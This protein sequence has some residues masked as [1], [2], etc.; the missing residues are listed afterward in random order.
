MHSWLSLK[1][2]INSAWSKVWLKDGGAG[3]A[4]GAEVLAAGGVLAGSDTALC[5]PEEPS[6][7]AVPDSTAPV[8]VHPAASAAVSSRAA[9][10]QAAVRGRWAMRLTRS[11]RLRLPP[12]RVEAVTSSEGARAQLMASR[13]RP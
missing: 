4:V 7:P 5:A 8:K 10:A 9:S 1:K 13:V 11:R 3:V 6:S 12:V 2:E